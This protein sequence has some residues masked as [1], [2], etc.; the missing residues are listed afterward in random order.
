MTWL[1]ILPMGHLFNTTRSVLEEREQNMN[2]RFD[3]VQYCFK[4][5]ERFPEKLTIRDIG[6]QALAAVGAGSDTVAA[7][8]QAFIYHMIRHPNA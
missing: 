5:N 3:A 2:A 8:I 7:G 6:T 1:S 4:Q